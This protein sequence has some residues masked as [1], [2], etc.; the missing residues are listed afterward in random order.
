MKVE[1][2]DK[3]TLASFR[4]KITAGYI[5]LNLPHYTSQEQ[6]SHSGEFTQPRK[7][8]LQNPISVNLEWVSL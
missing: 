7:T 6:K 3:F 4:S 2:C 5:S 8:F 1:E